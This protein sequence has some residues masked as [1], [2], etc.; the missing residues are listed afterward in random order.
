MGCKISEAGP[1]PPWTT[2]GSFQEGGSTLREMRRRSIFCHPVGVPL[3]V[4]LG[5]LLAL[6]FLFG[7]KADIPNTAQQDQAFE[8]LSGNSLPNKNR[9]Y[10]SAVLAKFHNDIVQDPSIRSRWGSSS[11]PARKPLPFYLTATDFPAIPEN[12]NEANPVDL[13]NGA[14]F[15]II[16]SAK[17]EQPPLVVSAT[18][19]PT[20]SSPATSTFCVF[21]Q[22]RSSTSASFNSR[23]L[24]STSATGAAECSARLRTPAPRT[25]LDTAAAASR[26]LECSQWFAW[27]CGMPA[28]GKRAIW[29]A[30]GTQTGWCRTIPEKSKRV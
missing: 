10:A 14:Y 7:A 13:V 9:M 26:G 20:H 15:G 25:L 23:K 1:C 2:D 4:I 18:K 17:Y 27:R 11:A 29:K 24:F 8:V 5:A 12:G 28:A 3:E 6:T 30:S 22:V 16:Q 19:A 21:D